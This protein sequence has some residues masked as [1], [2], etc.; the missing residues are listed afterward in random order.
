MN[1]NINEAIA[2]LESAEDA[3]YMDIE[4]DTSEL[5]LTSFDYNSYDGLH[6]VEFD[7]ESKVESIDGASPSTWVMLHEDDYNRAMDLLDVAMNEKA[8]PAVD[9]DLFKEALASVKAQLARLEAH[10]ENL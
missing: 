5:E 8:K 10:M 2:I 3:S 4:L 1:T 9:V 7:G 6:N